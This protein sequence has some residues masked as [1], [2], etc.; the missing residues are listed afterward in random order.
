MKPRSIR[1]AGIAVAFLAAT[2]TAAQ[3]ELPFNDF[4]LHL[5]DIRPGMAVADV[6]AGRG[7]FAF[8]MAPRVG[9]EGHVYANEISRDRIDSIE[10]AKQKSGISNLTVV[11]GAVDDAL[12]PARVDRLVMVDVYHHLD[13]SFAF[14]KNLQKYLKPE[15]RLF[16]AA[17]LNKRNP[18]APPRKS[19]GAD[20][21]VSDPEETRKAIEKAGFIFEEVV[22]H[23]DPARNF[24]WPTSYVLVFRL[25]EQTMARA[26]ITRAGTA[27]DAGQD[28]VRQA[29]RR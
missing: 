17:V 28:R 9:A 23:D 7:D 11:R 3:Q 14:M 10:R 19:K 15:G 1:L 25:A 4:L 27:A 12:L 18:K 5:L 2:F 13:E 8:L 22:M 20:P 16:V 6:G 24:F 29:R 21:C 26:E